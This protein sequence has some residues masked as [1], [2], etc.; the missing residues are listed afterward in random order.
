MAEE[1]NFD[2][3]IYGDGAEEQHDSATTEEFKTED[4]DAFI[5]EENYTTPAQTNG[6]TK[7][8]PETNLA[9]ESY[10]A[11]EPV[12][13]IENIA[14]GQQKIS[15]TDGSSQDQLHPP[16]QPPQQQGAKRKEGPDT[17]PIDVGATSAL[18]IS[19]LHWW[20]TDDDIR[21]WINQSEC[22]D[23][24]KDITFNEHK[25]NGK[26]KGYLF[27]VVF[28][29]P[30]IRFHGLTP[31]T[32]SRQAFI[33]LISPQA[34]TAVKQKIES[35]GAGQQYAKKHTVTYTAASTNP[36]RTLPK[37]APA[38]GKDG[39]RERDNRST[40][41]SFNSP[42]SMGGGANPAP[43]NFGMNNMG[44]GGFRGGRGGYN[45]RGAPMH[46]MNGGYGNR[47]FSGPMPTPHGGFQG[48]PMGGFQGGPMGG[49]Q[50]FGN[51][52]NRGGMMGGMR[53]GPAGM[54]GGRGGMGMTGMMSGL[55]MGGMGM[56][57]GMGGMSGPMGGMAGN[58][59]MGQMA[60]G[61]QGT[62]G[63]YNPYAAIG[64]RGPVVGG[65][66]YGV[67][68]PRAATYA[69][70]GSP[71]IGYAGFSGVPSHSVSPSPITPLATNGTLKRSMD[72]TGAGGF[73][74]PTPHFNPAFFNQNQG[75]GGDGSWNPHG[76]KRP[77]PE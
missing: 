67:A 51:F 52:H 9:P 59:G 43:T 27:F 74:S 47:S 13:G 41:G 70:A 72:Q 35:F 15:T 61:M 64:Y 12:E 40:T 56:G 17:R 23:E 8:E 24:L 63:F 37:D 48:A 16:K 39:P 68:D 5:F 29:H 14:S 7:I 77:R 73:H 57:M 6:D 31:I 44:G 18:F 49:M 36:F 2:I 11:P 25:V 34:A 38:R 62:T 45:N 42:G 22:E 60:G 10:K 66:N 20:T 1:D 58:M 76:A 26:S 54:R 21:G 55:P 50:Q 65:F 19:D 28:H 33:E 32:V 75:G 30:S 53:G 3:D 71:N 4:P 69:A 46:N